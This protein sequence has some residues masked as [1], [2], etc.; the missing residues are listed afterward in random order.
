MAEQPTTHPRRIAFTINDGVFNSTPA[1]AYVGIRQVNDPPR[2]TLDANG[3]LDKM[4][5][6]SEGQTEP[7]ILA[8]ELAIQGVFVCVWLLHDCLFHL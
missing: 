7:L 5:V 8:P 6:F 3:T 1:V 4:V 2:V